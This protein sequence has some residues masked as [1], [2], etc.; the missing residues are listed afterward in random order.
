MDIITAILAHFLSSFVLF[1]LLL[2]LIDILPFLFFPPPL[3]F[4]LTFS[5]SHSLSRSFNNSPAT[6]TPL[7]KT[8]TQPASRRYKSQIEETK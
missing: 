8:A 6:S 5:L 4:S 1:P 3:S 7:R 2:L